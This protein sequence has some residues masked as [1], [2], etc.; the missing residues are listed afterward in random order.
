MSE[1][2][3]KFNASEHI[4]N[5]RGKDYLPVAAR[6]LWCRNEH[7]QAVMRT[8]LMEWNQ[9]EGWCLYRAEVTLPEGGHAEA[10]ATQNKK[11]FPQYL[12]KCESK[13][14]GR[15]LG[16]LGYGTL[17]VE[18]EDPANPNIVDTPIARNVP[19][20]RSTAPIRPQD[21]PQAPPAPIAPEP[22][23]EAQERT[24]A[25]ARDMAEARDTVGAVD[26]LLRSLKVAATPGQW[27]T[28]SAHRAKLIARCYPE[29]QMNGGNA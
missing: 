24:V 11:D 28:I 16:F 22:L 25:E 27:K 1:D 15:A 10:T 8:T 9:T 23:T 17:A 5:L 12:E 6:I 2:H 7:P 3:V 4:M 19:A 18:D 29:A 21:E 13:A 20:P 14:L 26:A